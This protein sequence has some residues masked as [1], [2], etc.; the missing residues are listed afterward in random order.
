MKAVVLGDG[1]K[2]KVE[3]CYVCPIKRDDKTYPYCAKLRI[4]LRKFIENKTTPDNCPLEDF[5]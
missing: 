1:T 4:N 2:R 5:V 3:G